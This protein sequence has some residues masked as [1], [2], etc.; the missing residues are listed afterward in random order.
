MTGKIKKLIKCIL[1][2][3]YSALH[4]CI[5]K[6]RKKVLFLDRH[7]RRDSSWALMQQMA[8]AGGYS[9]VYHA[10]RARPAALPAGVRWCAGRARAYLHF[11]TSPLVFFTHDPLRAFIRPG[12]GQRVVNLWHGT[13]LKDISL[14][15]EGD[16]PLR[17]A[18]T[19]VLSASEEVDGLMCKTFGCA[20]S[21]VLTEGY[22]RND[23]LFAEKDVFDALSIDRRRYDACALWMP[24]FRNSAILNRRDS[25]VDFPLL[26]EQNVWALDAFLAQ[27]RQL[28]LIKL[29]PAADAPAYLLAGFQNIR[30]ITEAELAAAQIQGYELLGRCDMLLTDFSSV[31]FDF[32]LTQKPIIFVF[33]D[34]ESYAA[35][36]GFFFSDPESVMPGPIV[37]DVDGLCAALSAAARGEDA[38][39]ARRDEICARFNRY[40]DG[41]SGQRLLR[42]LEGL[43]G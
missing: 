5:P 14:F 3:L 22:P 31:Y 6:R 23:W 30:L 41:H 20:P 10:G 32:L 39:A 28:L 15:A 35:N 2:G 26:N 7:F 27:N 38:Y 16:F 25:D 43:D 4:F 17:R 13:P 21:A 37:R 34:L 36:R 42:R 12:R 40:R 8:A 1:S 24:T 11:L 18:F 33:D 29:H 19:N 9:L